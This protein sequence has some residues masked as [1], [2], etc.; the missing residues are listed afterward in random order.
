MHSPKI[1]IKNQEAIQCRGVAIQ[2]RITTEDPSNNFKPDYGTLIAY[3]NAGGYGIR[4]D[5]GSS[6][7]GVK[8]SPFFDSMLAKV[9][10]QGRTLSGASKR[11][12]RTLTEFRI[13][14]VKTNIP[15][16]ENV[17][18]HPVFREGGAT[19]KFIEQY[20]ELFH[21]KIKQ[22]SGTKVLNY[23]ADV[24]VNGNPDVTRID[25]SKNF[26]QPRLPSSSLRGTKQSL[27]T[28]GTK[29]KLTELGPEKFSRHQWLGQAFLL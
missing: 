26:S 12:Y 28:D 14:G 20:P 29:Q 5:E 4:I 24:L 7:Q 22:D 23:L 27:P 10:A 13:R 9:T 1:E 2:C 3:R 8:V 11:M 15:F 21:F 19:V 18:T 6:Y 17:I 25:T 16:L